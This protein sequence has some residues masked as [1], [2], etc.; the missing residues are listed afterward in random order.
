MRGIDSSDT[1]VV[2]SSPVEKQA[3]GMDMLYRLY[4]VYGISG[5]LASDPY[6]PPFLKGVYY[7]NGM[8]VFQVEGDTVA[9]R[10]T[11]EQKT[12]SSA[13]HLELT[14][15]SLF[16]QKDLIVLQRKVR[17]RL[18]LPENTDVNANVVGYGIGAHHLSINLIVNTPESQQAFRKKIIDSPALQFS[19]G[20]MD[21]PCTKEG[22][23][24][25]LGV[26]LKTTSPSF[27]AQSETVTF[28]LS[29]ESGTNVHY[30]A[31]YSLAYEREGQWYH[32]PINPNVISIGYVLFP[33]KTEKLTAHLYPDVHPNNPG[34]YRYF[35]EI[36]IG[37]NR[38]KILLMAEFRLED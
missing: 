25:T 28:I 1:L 35:K 5:D 3:T 29:N 12:G 11:L 16:S 6:C 4:K 21:E 19:G 26:H 34:R 17:Q 31:D 14:G 9:I 7:D 32:L 10:Q 18:A 15:D 23:S 36:T 22:I 8:L 30:G 24:G 20:R 37:D 2:K 33:G 38:E 13:F 27:S